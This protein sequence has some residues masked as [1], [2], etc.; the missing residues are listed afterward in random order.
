[1][2]LGFGFFIEEDVFFS[3]LFFF[4]SSQ[5]HGGLVDSRMLLL[6]LIYGIAWHCFGIDYGVWELRIDD[7]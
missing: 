2:V 6:G 4:S 1:M 5:R 7:K 3:F